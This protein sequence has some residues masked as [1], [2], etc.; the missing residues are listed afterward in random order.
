MSGNVP[1]D[2]DSP[3]VLKERLRSENGVLKSLVPRFPLPGW[4][5][6]SQP[7]SRNDVTAG[8]ASVQ[9]YY[10]SFDQLI[11]KGAF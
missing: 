3:R 6:H 7:A 2:S 8:R 1:G 4:R 5:V 11:T 9:Q 10:G